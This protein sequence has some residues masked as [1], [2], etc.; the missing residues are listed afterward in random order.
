MDLGVVLFLVLNACV[1]IYGS[2]WLWEKLQTSN[3]YRRINDSI[4]E[5]LDRYSEPTYS[6]TKYSRTEN[7]QP[8]H[9]NTGHFE[10]S[11]PEHLNPERSKPI[12]LYQ[13]QYG[14]KFNFNLFG[15]RRGVFGMSGSGKGN[16]LQLIVLEVLLLGPRV[17]EMI[18]FDRKSGVDYAAFLATPGFTLYK[19][20]SD[21]DTE[22]FTNALRAEC[23]EM[24]RRY[25][26]ILFPTK[27]RN[28]DE[29]NKI[30]RVPLC[31]RVILIDE[32]ADCTAEQKEYI[33]TLVA[34][35]R[36]AGY[37]IIVCTQHPL[38]TH[39]SSTIQ[40]NLDERYVLK[41]KPKQVRVATGVE[42]KDEIEIDPAKLST[43]GE[44]VLINNDGW[45][46]FKTPYLSEQ[47]RD[48]LLDEISCRYS[49]VL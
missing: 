11:K 26:D 29:Y 27:K 16:L 37:V 20:R 48:R 35:S 17:A 23:D 31:H 7:K 10:Y 15:G 6:F 33:E 5:F 1:V 42:T 49:E 18:V 34:M 14:Q 28:L 19:G 30:A 2:I 24:T 21:S 25:D 38:A 3:T 41:V 36:A 39:V 9:L 46:Y 32:I 47:W 12:W 45:T 13:D 8:D 22:K 43:V 44:G 40:A 4:S